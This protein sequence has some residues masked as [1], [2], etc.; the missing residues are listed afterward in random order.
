MG[1]RLDVITKTSQDADALQ[2]AVAHINEATA[3]RLPDLHARVQ[4]PA[5]KKTTSSS[6]AFTPMVKLKPIKTIDL[7]AVLQDALRHAG[8]SFNHTS[9]EFLQNSLLKTQLE[10]AE[11]LKDHHESTSAS[12]HNTLAERLHKVDGDVNIITDALYKHTPFQEVS[13]ASSELQEQLR[14]MEREME[15]KDRQLLE[16][17][18]NELSLSDPKVR[19]FMAKY[20]K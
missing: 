9:I 19:A 3:K 11:K 10:R 12:S 14:S 8:I 18:A 16:A 5:L 2:Q 17:E 20:G 13:L 4:T 7:P 15:E 6:S 1:K